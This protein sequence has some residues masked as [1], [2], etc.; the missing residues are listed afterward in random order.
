MERLKGTIVDWNDDR[1]YGFIEPAAGGKKVFCHIRSFS[2]RVKRPI[3]GD[4]VTYLLSN[5]KQDRPQ[6]TS[7]RPSGLEDAKYGS[8]AR[9]QKPNPQRAEP[10][11]FRAMCVTAFFATLVALVVMARLPW[12]VPIAYLV[13]SGIT[14]FAYAFDKSAA[15]NKRWRTQEQTLHFL[16]LAGGWPGA[17]LAQLM[18]QHKRRKVSFMVEFW[19]CALINLAAL[20]W[21][22]INLTTHTAVK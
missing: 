21:Y 14:L 13:M 10:T 2:V 22:A 3:S 17:W 7:V 9:K 11:L 12:Y 20:S 18:F 16:E 15:L 5:G 19:I 1:G 8:T 6:A 4:R